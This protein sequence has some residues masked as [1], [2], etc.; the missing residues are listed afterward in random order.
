MQSF[1]LDKQFGKLPLQFFDSCWSTMIDIDNIL[2]KNTVFWSASWKPSCS[3]IHCDRIAK[4]F[5][6]WR[7]SVKISTELVGSLGRLIQI[8]FVFRWVIP[9]TTHTLFIG[10]VA[11]SARPNN[12]ADRR[13]MIL[14]ESYVYSLAYKLVIIAR[15]P[16]RN[17]D[18]LRKNQILLCRKYIWKWQYLAALQKRLARKYLL[19]YAY[20]SEWSEGPFCTGV[21]RTKLPF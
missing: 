3:L 4:A 15:Y 20:S 14:Q 21:I 5:S 17:L 12:W 2:E 9:N 6:S 1:N 7:S 8:S 13:E 19:T 11:R 10:V 16:F 18:L